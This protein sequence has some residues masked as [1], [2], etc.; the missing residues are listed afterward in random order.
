M[1]LP[2]TNWLWQVKSGLR[3]GGAKLQ[4]STYCT[5]RK[6]E[7]R[8]VVSGFENVELLEKREINYNVNLVMNAKILPTSI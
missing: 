1:L 6:E 8:Y 7:I 5:W 4:G 2:K 3:G